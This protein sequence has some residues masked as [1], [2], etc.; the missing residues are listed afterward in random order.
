[1]KKYTSF[2][3][4]VVASIGMVFAQRE[5]Y[6]LDSHWQFTP[7]WTSGVSLNV[8]VPHIWEKGVRG[9][10]GYVKMCDIPKSFEKRI[11]YLRF[12]GVS[13]RADVFINS[14]YL[15]THTGG[16][17][18]FAYNLSGLLTYGAR[19]TFWLRVDNSVDL[20]QMPLAGDFDVYGGIFRDA[21]L[22]SVPG[23]HICI[24]RYATDGVYVT[25]QLSDDGNAEV[26]VDAKLCLSSGDKTMVV[27]TILDDDGAV[28]DSVVKEYRTGRTEERDEQVSF[29]MVSP[30]LWNGTEDPYLYSLR[31]RV[32]SVTV[33]GVKTY[34]QVDVPFGI[35]K[36]EVTSE[37]RFML[38]GHPYDVKG[39]V[40]YED[41]PVYGNALGKPQQDKDMSLL[42][43]IG[44]NAVRLA[45]YPQNDY[46]LSLCDRYGIL[47]WSELPFAGPQNGQLS[48][49]F[50]DS[51]RFRENGKSQL[52]DMLH[53]QYNHPSVCFVGL[54]N[55]LILRGDNPTMY[56]SELE[57]LA[58]RTDGSRL[59][60]ASSV[61]DGGINGITD[62]IGFNQSFGWSGGDLEDFDKWGRDVRSHFPQLKTGISAYGAGGSVLQQ[63]E[64][65]VK[66]DKNGSFHPE[67][68]Q[69][70]F[71]ETYWKSISSGRYFWGTFVSSLFD[72][73]SSSSIGGYQEGVSD[74]G[75][76]SYDRHFRKDA[77]YFYKANWNRDDMF[78]HIA[79]LRSGCISVEEREVKIY[80]NEESVSL[81]LNGELIGQM[82]G[83][84][85][86]FRW[87]SVRFVAGKNTLKAVGASG[88]EESTIVIYNPRMSKL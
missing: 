40:R 68:W 44:A 58:K 82:S 22:I 64:T 48:K 43:E 42:M 54:Y 85:G 60:V 36:V 72:H 23:T 14:K 16:Y 63:T 8:D 33:G 31:V 13:Q 15:D 5:V 71:H 57:E 56:V 45:G 35:R 39:V 74:N 27:F 86:I 83:E 18:A 55:E 34:D 21:E 70:L 38:N 49:G 4:A 53:Q 52:I 1:M 81:F 28:V 76:V 59:T 75:L 88:T 7:E 37:N 66:P 47:V 17:S 29:S 20:G 65:P 79:D 25:P 80:S 77:F 9:L 41:W 67:Q 46:F 11:V 19:N 3:V 51:E 30:H 2:I 87:P 69:S 73:A 61:Q 12:K 26:K 32:E 6:D 78:V 24:D 50:V 84:L 62:L 10:G